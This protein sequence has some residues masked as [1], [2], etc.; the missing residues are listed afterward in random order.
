MQELK[1]P[2]DSLLDS[3]RH[4]HLAHT[5]CIL[6]LAS[7][8][9]Q[10]PFGATTL[11]Q[12]CCNLPMNTRQQQWSSQDGFFDQTLLT[13]IEVKVSKHS[14]VAGNS[15]HSQPTHLTDPKPWLF[16]HRHMTEL[17]LKRF[18]CLLADSQIGEHDHERSSAFLHTAR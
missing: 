9:L 5:T 4:K 1:K 15:M 16:R 14:M 6:L 10:L 13:L 12:I 18:N 7:P 3:I 11:R 17:Q 8:A 2:A